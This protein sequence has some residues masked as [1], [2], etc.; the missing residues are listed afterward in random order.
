MKLSRSHPLSEDPWSPKSS[1]LT[2]G[3][4]TCPLPAHHRLLSTSN[5]LNQFQWPRCLLQQCREL[6]GRGFES[7]RLHWVTVRDAQNNPSM[8]P[9]SN[10][11]P[12]V[13]Q[14]GAVGSP[15]HV[16]PHSCCTTTYGDAC[17]PA[18]PVWFQLGEQVFVARNSQAMQRDF[19]SQ[20]AG[21]TSLGS[22]SCQ[23]TTMATRTTAQ[24]SGSSISQ[25]RS[26]ETG[27]SDRS[28]ARR[29]TLRTLSLVE[30][31][32]SSKAHPNEAC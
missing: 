6:L 16:K 5:L 27:K 29:Q 31:I 26:A 2:S 22:E 17:V 12:C 10:F 19:Q 15:P 20:P 13:P 30:L 1:S 24:A 23:A 14:L 18:I 3:R 11:T 25:T 21:C 7:V 28:D 32:R 8:P 9:A 4:S